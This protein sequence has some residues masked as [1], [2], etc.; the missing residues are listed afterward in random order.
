M[1]HFLYVRI[2][3]EFDFVFWMEVVEPFV[4]FCYKIYHYCTKYKGVFY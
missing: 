4:V 1:N 2:L 3:F